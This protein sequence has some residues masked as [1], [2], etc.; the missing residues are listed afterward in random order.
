MAAAW[1]RRVQRWAGRDGGSDEGRARSGGRSGSGACEGCSTAHLAPRLD[2]VRA[3]LQTQP[4]PRHASL[5]VALVATRATGR[6]GRRARGRTSLD[7]GASRHAVASP[8]RNTPARSSLVA[9]DDGCLEPIMREPLMLQ[10]GTPS[11]ARS[12]NGG[13]SY[14]IYNTSISNTYIYTNKKRDL[15][16]SSYSR[17]RLRQRGAAA[18]RRSSR[19]EGCLCGSARIQCRL[20]PCRSHA[21]ASKNARRALSSQHATA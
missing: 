1:A 18:E 19:L 14:H 9:L 10:A 13:N 21:A 2:G 3:G 11:L 8:V 20:S 5:S 6:L 16:H 4:C 15:S 12:G 17:I 7:G